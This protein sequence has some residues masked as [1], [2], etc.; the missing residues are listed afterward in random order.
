MV[1]NRDI[2]IAGATG[3]VGV[4]LGQAL[5]ARG[6]TVRGLVRQGSESKLPRGVA[7]VVANALDAATWSHAVRPSDTLVHLVGTPRPNPSKAKQF[8]EVDLASIRVSVAAA[9][10]GGVRHLVYVSV[11]HPAPVMA[12]YVAAR[13]QGE[14][15]V[16]EAGVH[17]TILRPWYV[18]GRGHWW[19]YAL[20]PLY[21]VLE[22]I[23]STARGARRLGLVTHRQMIAALVH[24]VEN[25]PD[26]VRIVEVPNIRRARLE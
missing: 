22:R 18:L 6:H 11:A 25:P 7:P 21:A 23:P 9:L 16:R 8:E 3:Y 26:G 13:M 24:A 19:P 2:L 10:A 5:V 20:V 1:A 12:A 17:A 14:R 4:A 15:L